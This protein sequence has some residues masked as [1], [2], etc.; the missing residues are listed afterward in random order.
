MQRLT[1]RVVV[2]GIYLRAFTL[3]AIDHLRRRTYG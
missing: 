2:L 1:D 3:T